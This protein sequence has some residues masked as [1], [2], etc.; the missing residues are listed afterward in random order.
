MASLRNRKSEE[1]LGEECGGLDGASVW[2]VGQMAGDRDT[3]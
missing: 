2:R 1:A 3:L